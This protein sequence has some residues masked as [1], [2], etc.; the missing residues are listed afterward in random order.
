MRLLGQI[1]RGGA[2]VQ[3]CDRIGIE[4][5]RT[6]PV[7]TGEVAPPEAIS[8]LGIVERQRLDCLD[9]IVVKAFV[10]VQSENPIVACLRDGEGLLGAVTQVAGE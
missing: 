3:S 10:G 9:R 6:D 7:V 2:V 8:L 5:C 1:T 4:A